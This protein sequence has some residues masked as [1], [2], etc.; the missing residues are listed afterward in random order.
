MGGMLSRVAGKRVERA[1]DML[2]RYDVK[3]MPTQAVRFS[4]K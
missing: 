2:T 4:A 1:N 3:A